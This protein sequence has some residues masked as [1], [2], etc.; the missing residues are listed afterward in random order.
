MPRKKE[1]G[2]AFLM[3]S[4]L[5]LTILGSM[6]VAIPGDGVVIVSPSG[7]TT[8]YEDWLN[9]QNALSEGSFIHLKKGMYYLAAPVIAMN[10][11]GVLKGAG[12]GSIIM[13]V[14][15]FEAVDDPLA[16]FCFYQDGAADVGIEKLIL[17]AE[18]DG[19]SGIMIVGTMQGSLSVD[20]CKFYGLAA[21]VSGMSFV[22]SVIE[23]K[24]N[25][26]HDVGQ[27]MVLN[28]P[29]ENS[30]VSISHNLVDV[31]RHGVEVYDIEN[32]EV[33]IVHNQIQGIYD[34]SATYETGAAINV[35]QMSRYGAPGEVRIMHN[36]I[37]GYTRWDWGYDMVNVLD[38]GAFAG[39]SGNLEAIIAHNTIEL[40]DSVWGGIGVH[41]GM[42]N[43]V[44]AFNTISGSGDAAIYIC[45]WSQWGLEDMSGARILFN[46]VSDFTAIPY[47]G[48]ID[49]TAPIWIGPGVSESLIVAFDSSSVLDVSG[50]NT[51]VIVG[52]G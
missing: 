15:D 46:D 10:F 30:V 13:A 52:H 28:G 35:I 38:F 7:D 16:L 45:F 39:V 40:D 24:H 9:V 25:E 51:V 1:V 23:M 20:D 29:I 41:G 22:D 37:Q 27:S 18:A 11:D 3:C 19:V 26:F 17:G 34:S 6:A 31:A 12:G 21:G 32:T 2:L 44:I 48:L 42:D 50:S 47:P 8:G 49:P 5:S 33:S 36:Y 43:P 4:L 14:S